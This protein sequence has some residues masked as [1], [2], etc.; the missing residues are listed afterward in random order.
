MSEVLKD[1]F[2]T[3]LKRNGMRPPVPDM[4]GLIPVA[5][6]KNS[7]VLVDALIRAKPLPNT[8]TVIS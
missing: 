8:F 5:V 2:N 1:L 6:N 4:V 7:N 3:Q